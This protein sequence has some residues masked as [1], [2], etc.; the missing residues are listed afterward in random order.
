MTRNQKKFILILVVLLIALI[1]VLSLYWSMIHFNPF[2]W[3]ANHSSSFL[4]IATI[5]VCGGLFAFGT[6][7]KYRK[8]L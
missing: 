2:T 7:L 3:I 6:W 8:T 4:T 5:C 1:G